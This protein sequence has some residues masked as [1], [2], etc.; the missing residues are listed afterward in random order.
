MKL[1]Q[2][3]L[4]EQSHDDGGGECIA[5]ADGVSDLHLEARVFGALVGR[6]Q[7]AASVAAR[8]T[9]QLYVMRRKQLSSRIFLAATLQFEQSHDLWKF[10]MV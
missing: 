2:G 9:D 1:A 8:D 10:L 5:R 6:Y 3:E 4:P 7:K